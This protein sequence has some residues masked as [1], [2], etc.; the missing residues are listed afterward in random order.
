MSAAVLA[1]ALFQTGC[2][3]NAKDVEEIEQ[4]SEQF[5]EAF[6]EGDSSAFKDLV[7]GNF[8]YDFKGNENGDILIK[9]ASKTEIQGFSDVEVNRR[10]LS[11]KAR[12]KISYID[13]GEFAGDLDGYC[14]SRSSYLKAIDEYDDRDSKNIQFSFVFDEDEGL[15]K[16]DESSAEKYGQLFSKYANRFNVI[17]M[18][19]DEAQEIFNEAF[20]NF[21]QGEFSFPSCS[22][23]LNCIRIF[24]NC[25]RNDQVVKDAAKVFAMAYFRYI[26]DHGYTIEQTGNNPYRVTLK[27]YA[28]SKAEILAYISSDEYVMADY[29]IRIR[30]VSAM[31]KDV[32]PD[33]LRSAIDA[34]LYYGLAERI[35]DMTPE[36][37]SVD[38][39]IDSVS[40][41][42]ADNPG[43][44]MTKGEELFVG[45]YD[46]N[47]IPISSKEV[48]DAKTR[49]PEQEFRCREQVLN[50]LYNSGE[51]PVQKYDAYMLA[52]ERDRY[53]ESGGTVPEYE[54]LRRVDW[55][56]TE[57][58][59]NQ[60]VNVTEY[61]PDFSDGQ[62]VY[63]CSDYDNSGIS[64]Q[65]SREPGWLDTAGYNISDDGITVILRYDHVFE[66]GTKLIYDWYI[67]GEPCQDSV[68][69][70]VQEDGTA[71]FEFT[72][73]GAE[74]GKYSE[75]EFRLWEE[76]HAHVLVY[77]QLFY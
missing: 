60:A 59:A 33:T 42:S 26:V 30:S 43:G 65:Y 76:D 31:R 18:S 21:A 32:N 4:V 77:V 49:T 69:F 58:H 23:D 51:I 38:L 1:S 71:E 25:G 74:I 10:T 2:S 6:G 35:P 46:N 75:C 61:L 14:M 15:W 44:S 66:K 17:S 56:G 40:Y 5:I 9:M 34:E 45:E 70:T 3:R 37:Y 22:F 52:V 8:A 68:E 29:E 64:M 20:R 36:E 13:P 11:A 63:G 7:D 48:S 54:F 73:T 19:E 67:D 55:S 57:A 12:V 47:V 24:D 72:L 41:I 50:S 16:V 28:P 27:G 62:I 39:S 53:L